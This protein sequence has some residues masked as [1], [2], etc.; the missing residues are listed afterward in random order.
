M[1]KVLSIS[2]NCVFLS[3]FL[4]SNARSVAL[5]GW[6]RTQ[7]ANNGRDRN[8]VDDI[9]DSGRGK[10]EVSWQ[11]RASATAR[12]GH[13]LGL[14]TRSQRCASSSV[15]AEARPGQ[16]RAGYGAASILSFAAGT[17][18]TW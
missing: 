6:A 5:K 13:E 9:L 11:A 17:D 18:P 15:I 14:D 10:L 7:E 1:R 4:S 3:V 16:G 2:G 8:R 12:R